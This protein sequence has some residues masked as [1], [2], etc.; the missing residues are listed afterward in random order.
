MRK[1]IIIAAL[2]LASI[3][4]VA[5]NGNNTIALNNTDEQKKEQTSKKAE[6]QKEIEA[7]K[8]KEEVSIFDNNIL[9][10]EVAAKADKNKEGK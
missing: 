1:F 6:A 9:H 5:Q 10:P 7:A 4:A 3:T 2:T 8:E